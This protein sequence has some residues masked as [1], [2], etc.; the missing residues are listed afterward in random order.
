MINYDAHYAK[1]ANIL[2]ELSEK[3]GSDKGSIIEDRMHRSGWPHHCYT[4]IYDFFLS[5]IRNTA[6]DILECG[7]GTNNPNLPSSMGPNG[8]PGASLRM[9]RDY[10]P[11]AEIIGIDIDPNIMFSEDRIKTFVVDQVS[12]YSIQKFKDE[13]KVEFDLI[14]DDG[15]HQYIPQLTLFE[16]MFDRVKQGGIY[17]IE[18]CHGS[19]HKLLKYLKENKYQCIGFY[20][21]RKHN[22]DG[23]DS[24]ILVKK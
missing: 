13:V 6:S 18:D 17:I 2:S 7:I 14:V 23:W 16:N 15:L 24:F 20:G 1:Q 19:Y 5:G 22:I 4:D 10:F 9:W 12:P 8:Q 3:Y 21:E 11:N